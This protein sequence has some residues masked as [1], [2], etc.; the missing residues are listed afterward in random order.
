MLDKKCAS[1]EQAGA[2]FVIAR[3]GAQHRWIS[4][5]KAI[6]LSKYFYSNDFKA[7]SL[8]E[9]VSLDLKLAK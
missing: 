6:L 1:G 5:E 3:G 9:T 4:R 8:S 7:D 2:H